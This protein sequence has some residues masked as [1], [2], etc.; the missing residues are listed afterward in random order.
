MGWAKAPLPG[1]QDYR[2]GT[3]SNSKTHIFNN[4]K[5][6]IDN[7]NPTQF[8]LNR[9]VAPP[10]CCFLENLPSI[11]CHFQLNSLQWLTAQP[12]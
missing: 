9:G 4:T 2:A 10:I 8:G 12:K 11:G 5:E 1:L 3:V 7:L 6:P